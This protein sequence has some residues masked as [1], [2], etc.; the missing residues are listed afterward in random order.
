[1]DVS[2]QNIK[3]NNAVEKG[4]VCSTHGKQTYDILVQKYYLTENTWEDNV[5]MKI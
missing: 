3:G 1:V 2:E 5:T 4:K